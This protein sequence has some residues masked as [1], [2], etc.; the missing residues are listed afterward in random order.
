M[1]LRSFAV[2]EEPDQDVGRHAFV[3]AVED[4]L[5][6]DLFADIA[7][8]LAEAARAQL[9]LLHDEASRRAIRRAM[10]GWV[11]KRSSSHGGRTENR[12]ILKTQ[13]AERGR[14]GARLLG[15]TRG[16]SIGSVSIKR[17]SQRLR[18]FSVAPATVTSTAIQKSTSGLKP[19]GV[20]PEQL[21]VD[22]RACGDNKMGEKQAR[23]GEHAAESDADPEIVIAVVRELVREHELDLVSSELREQRVADQRPAR[24]AEAHDGGVG[25]VRPPAEVDLV[26]AEHG[27]PVR[28][29]SCTKRLVSSA[30][31]SG[32]ILK[33]IGIRSCGAIRVST[34]P[35]RT[36]PSAA[37]IHQS[38]P[39]QRIVA[40]R[41][42]T[43]IEPS[44]APSAT[45]LSS[46]RSQAPSVWVE[47]PNFFSMT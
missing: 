45:P 10:H 42:S 17:E 35:K 19:P 2:E 33:K 7:V 9:Q 3:E 26:D 6:A 20:R 28:E 34:M 21:A 40:V 43:T 14:A 46:S 36:A 24:G 32:F 29:A 23:G 38:V 5:Q 1:C 30:S 4:L 41:P 12:Q 11:W 22:R 31:A 8:E 15:R 27:V 47:S 37:Q 44:S 16:E 13:L 18:G 25:G 39:V